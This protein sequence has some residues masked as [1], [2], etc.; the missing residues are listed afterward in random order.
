M[1]DNLF[2]NILNNPHHALHK[3]LPDKTDYTYDLRSRRQSL[4]LTVKT[5]R[6]NFLN[7]LLFKDIY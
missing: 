3:F 4:S 2:A 5:E 6:S 1:D 7:R